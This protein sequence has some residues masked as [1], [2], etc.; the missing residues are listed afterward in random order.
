MKPAELANLVEKVGIPLLTAAAAGFEKGLE[1]TA[2]KSVVK[3]EETT[4]VA[5]ASSLAADTNLIDKK[6]GFE[7]A[8][9]IG[10]VREVDSAIA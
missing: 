6:L 1:D 9:S 10:S 4:S 7:K 3:P 8:L 2:E 5:D